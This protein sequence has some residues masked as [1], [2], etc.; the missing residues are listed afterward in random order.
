MAVKLKI[1][2]GDSVKVITGDDKG[3][4]GKVLAVY[5]KTLKVVVEGC[6]IAKKAI[7]PSEKN[8]NGGFIN[9]EMPIDIS[10][11]AKVQE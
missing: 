8:P 5:P 2:K 6:K 1:K 9:K 10:N 4:T 3:K 11:V 7:K